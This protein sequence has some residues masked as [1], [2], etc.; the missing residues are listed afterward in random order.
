[1]PKIHQLSD[2]AI[3]E[4]SIVFKHGA[5]GVEYAPR[6]PDA[7]V[8][9]TKAGAVVPDPASAA[10]SGA[11]VAAPVKK[12]SFLEKLISRAQKGWLVNDD[13]P[14]NIDGDGDG[15]ED[16]E[17]IISILSSTYYD[18]QQVMYVNDSEA[19]SMAITTCIDNFLERLDD[20]RSGGDGA[21]KSGT[22]KA[23]ARHSKADMATIGK[24]G[25][26]ADAMMK[27]AKAMKGHV[28]TLTAPPAD[29]EDAQ[30]GGKDD[31]TGKDD[32]ATKAAAV[33]KVVASVDTPAFKAAAGSAGVTAAAQIDENVLVEK[34]A[35]KVI[36][37]IRSLFDGIR[38]DVQKS[39]DA[40]GAA[41]DAKIA[42]AAKAG[43]AATTAVDT[44]KA[45][46]AAMVGDARK[47]GAVGGGDTLEPDGSTKKSAIVHHE[48]TVTKITPDMDATGKNGAI[49][50]LLRSSRS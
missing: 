29:A 12:A 26:T 43:E 17:Q 20:V 18:L 32:E 44:L 13:V 9:G 25:D 38:A 30:D 14:D 39:F 50:T 22:V 11:I 1:M 8:L 10:Q 37:E 16:Y 47:N 41:I 21:M 6:N 7:R 2:I 35:E 31:G 3:D 40:H 45:S 49:Q 27:H 34:T 4:L 28:A 15:A 33:A 42:T 19:R 23:G 46:V 5:N 48:A 24:M 36:G